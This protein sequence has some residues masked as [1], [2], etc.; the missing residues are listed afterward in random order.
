MHHPPF[1]VLA[2]FDNVRLMKGDARLAEIVRR[3]GTSSARRAADGHGPIQVRWGGT[4]ASNSQH[5]P[6]ISGGR[7]I[8]ALVW[9]FRAP[10]L[11][12]FALHGLAEPQVTHVSYIGDYEGHGRGTTP[13]HR[14]QPSGR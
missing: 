4:V 6:Y 3:H 13:S 7:L 12:N 8:C 2:A 14:Q 10:E 1:D 5:W 11:P 9:R